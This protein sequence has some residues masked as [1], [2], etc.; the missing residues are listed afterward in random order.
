MRIITR[1]RLRLIMTITIRILG[2]EQQ[3]NTSCSVVRLTECPAEVCV[4]VCRSI[5]PKS[6]RRDPQQGALKA[7]AR[8]AP[9]VASRFWKSR[10]G[11]PGLRETRSGPPTH[12]PPREGMRAKGEKPAPS[13]GW[14]R[15][16]A[17]TLHA[18]I[19]EA[20]SAMG[21]RL[22]KAVLTCNVPQ[23][24]EEQPLH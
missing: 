1:I 20:R 2:K 8:P 12:R 19:G 9:P 13:P 10:A 14:A 4:C 23:R 7:E 17:C 6:E 21:A 24:P 3:L 22:T 11:L 5:G 15:A 16:V 18:A